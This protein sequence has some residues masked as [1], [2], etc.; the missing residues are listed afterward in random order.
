MA[1]IYEAGNLLVHVF[2]GSKEP[3]AHC[4]DRRDE[5]FRTVVIDLLTLLP[6]GYGEDQEDHQL[7]TWQ[8][9]VEAITSCAEH[10]EELWAAWDELRNDTAY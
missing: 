4:Y 5:S 2:N 7:P 8:L 10:E 1:Q 9:A 3:V 6:T